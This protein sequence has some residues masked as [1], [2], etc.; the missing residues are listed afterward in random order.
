MPFD[1]SKS[2]SHI[3]TAG[4]PAL[5]THLARVEGWQHWMPSRHLANTQ[6]RRGENMFPSASQFS[7][8]VVPRRARPGLVRAPWP[9]PSSRRSLR[10]RI[11][12][13]ASRPDT[14]RRLRFGLV[15]SRPERHARARDPLAHRA[16]SR[17]P[18]S[19]PAPAVPAEPRLPVQAPPRHAALRLALARQEPAQTEIPRSRRDA[20]GGTE[21]QT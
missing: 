2:R 13:R 6:S 20:R 12:N 1:K 15:R 16:A 4:R 17:L 11:C 3:R 7:G 21:P 8:A 18:A 19:F 14:A 5:R 10:E 9:R